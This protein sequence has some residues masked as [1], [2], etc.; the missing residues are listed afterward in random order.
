MSRRMPCKRTDFIR[1]LKAPGFVG[2]FSG[3][4]ASFLC[5]GITGSQR[6]RMKRIPFRSYG[7]Y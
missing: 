3:Q 7:F 4:C 6:R 5:T 1:R 2:K